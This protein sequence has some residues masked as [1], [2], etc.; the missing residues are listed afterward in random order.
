MKRLITNFKSAYLGLMTLFM[1]SVGLNVQQAQ[2]QCI[3][4]TQF[5]TAT[6]TNNGSIM[7]ATTCAFAGEYSVFNIS[8]AGIIN[9]TVTNGAYITLTTAANVVITHGY[10][11][12]LVPI[13][14]TGTY[15]LHVTT[16]PGCG[17]QSSCY[18]TTGQWTG[19]AC[20]QPTALAASNITLNSADFTWTAGGTE[21]EWDIYYGIAPLAAPTAGT[22]PTVAG[23][24]STTFNATGLLTAANYQFYIRSDCDADGLSPWSGPISF[25]TL[26]TCPAPTALAHSIVNPET[27]DLTWTAGAN[28]ETEWVVQYGTTGF[29]PGTG[30]Q[31]V[32][33]TTSANQLT[34]LTE[35]TSYQVYV[36]GVCAVGDSSTWHGPISF[37]TPFWCPVPSSLITNVVDP[38]TV[39][40]FWT[41]GINN[42]TE[43][44]IE[45]GPVG[46]TAG[47]GTIVSVTPNPTTTITGLTQNTAYSFYVRA[48]CS[49]T[50]S[51]LWVGP[52]NV[53]TP[54]WC[55][56]PSGFAASGATTSTVDLSWNP[57]AGAETEWNIQYG[58]SGFTIG[59]GT[60]VNTNN[61]TLE[62]LTG[63]NSGT[64]YQYYVQAVCGNGY[65][66]LY[67]GPFTFATLVTND[68]A[69]NAIVVPVDGIT[70]TFGNYG[71]TAGSQPGGTNNQ[72]VW[73]QFTVPASG[74]VAI[75]TCGT[76]FDTELSVYES[77]ADASVCGVY[78]S[79][80]EAVYADYHP[81]DFTTCT[82][83]HPAGV[84]L[85]GLTPGATH[86]LVVGNYYSGQA[87]NSFPLKLWD[88]GV[89]AGVGSTVTACVGDTVNLMGTVSGT[90]SE[91]MGYFAHTGNPFV[92]YD[93]SL[94][95][96]GN[97]PANGTT[98]YVVENLCMADTAFITVNVAQPASS[99]TAVSP[100]NACNTGTVFLP[101]G[102]TGTVTQGGTWT[103]NT[104]TGLLF[105]NQFEAKGL[106][107]GTYQFTYTVG[108]GGICPPSSTLVTVNLQNC[109]GVEENNMSFSIYPNPNNGQFFVTTNAT[110]LVTFEVMDI[111]GKIVFKTNA[112]MNAGVQNEINVT[113]VATGMYIVKM[114]SERGVSTQNVVI[115]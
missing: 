68:E 112:T 33:T 108:N 31:N 1:F 28:N 67:N 9:F 56:N 32:V 10:S 51:S 5:G 6:V 88:L 82:G 29:A 91:T 79:F 96:T 19:P 35:N 27:V 107:V 84:E 37:T 16:G 99:G 113:D 74:H 24:T 7:T 104:A 76:P 105:T 73:F 12:L 77:S 64:A 44:E 101:N 61:N 26:S 46:F 111:T 23:H 72:T 8:N 85:C 83:V 18:T 38:E 42:E 102:L 69:C 49:A 94:A 3:V 47:T 52:E 13:S 45:Y 39:Q 48:V 71:S 21:T 57:G 36:R 103:D 114:S 11:P 22:T 50:H 81:F 70:R 92:I 30:M 87:F 86:Y 93:D 43:W 20:I 65:T 63:L 60:V 17:S 54:L 55:P 98:I 4:G 90:I 53:T 62:Q 110:E 100:F 15:R 95:V 89:E 109:T 59:S 78:T 66:S 40:L 34:G 106:P 75:S 80:V 115:K 2:A 41:A 14:T 58:P 25:T 97:M